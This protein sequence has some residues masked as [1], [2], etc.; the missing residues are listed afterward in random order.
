MFP[1]HI[2]LPE[3]HVQAPTEGSVILASLL[4]KLGGYG[5]IR[6][7]LPMFPEGTQMFL[8]LV[9][10]LSTMGVVYASFTTICQVDL[11]KI[12]AYS[13]IAHMNF[14]VLGIFSLTLEGLQ[15]SIFLM[16]AHGIVSSGL[17]F[18]VGFLY[19]RYHVRELRYYGG[20]VYSMPLYSTFF[21]IFILA[22][23]SLPGTCNFIGEILIFFGLFQTQP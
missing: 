8:P 11:K 20:L 5:F 1:L 9:M 16:L 18:M 17:F 2:W 14:V 12:I 19:D 21:L 22:N 7:L 6:V 23:M 13:S 4:L 15:G 10:V 3:A